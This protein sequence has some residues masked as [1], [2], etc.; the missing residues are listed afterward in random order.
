MGLVDLLN[1][2]IAQVVAQL[3]E[4]FGPSAGKIPVGAFCN[5]L[6]EMQRSDEFAFDLRDLDFRRIGGNSVSNA[7][8]DFLFLGGAWG[9]HTVPNPA[10]STIS[11]DE[12]RAQKRLRKLKERYGE[13]G[14][15]KLARM[16]NRFLIGLQKEGYI[17][18]D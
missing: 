12:E 14:V 3:R 11:L 13:G 10:L 9:A 17:P 5:I 8:G 15:E 1:G 4:Q 16:A 18:Q 6:D 2:L 7:L